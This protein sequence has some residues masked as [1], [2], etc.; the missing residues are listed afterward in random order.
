MPSI[1]VKG[2]SEPQKVYA[3]IGRKD[4]PECPANLA[5]LREILG[6]EVK[7]E[8]TTEDAEAKEEKFEL[9]K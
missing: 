1:K 5:G 4:D 2:K 8:A 6:I 3:V 7:Q 9:V